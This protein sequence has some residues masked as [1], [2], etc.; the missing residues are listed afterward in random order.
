MK[1]E[2]CAEISLNNL[3][4]NIH[5]IQQR[6]SPSQVIPVVKADAYGH[7]VVSITRRLA[8]EGFS[9][10]AVAQLQEALELRESGITHSIRLRLM[11]ES[12]T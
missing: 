8:K 1:R 3:A 12:S 6:I 4:S 2:T 5:A 10:L 7:G 11:A 9:M